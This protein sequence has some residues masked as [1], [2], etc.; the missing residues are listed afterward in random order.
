M[1]EEIDAFT[2]Y[3]V[4]IRKS[5]KNTVL[6]YRRDLLQLLSYLEKQGITELPKVTRTSLN[7]YILYLEGQ[8]KATATI[9]RVVASMKAFFHYE[10]YERKIYRDPSELLKTPRIEKKAPVILTVEEVEQLLRQPEGDTPKELRDKAMLEL[11]YATGIRVSELIRLKLEDV[12]LQVGFITCRDGQKERVIPFG[13]TA[14]RALRNY[15]DQAREQ[16]LKGKESPWLFVNCNGS[17]LSRQG[18]WKILKYYGEKAGI[19]PD[20]TPHMLRRSFAV[21]LIRR[22]ADLQS[23]KNMLG[24]ADL[25]T[26]QMYMNFMEKDTSRLEGSGARSG[27]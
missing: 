10:M 4:N 14:G 22:G 6:S 12:N 21:H 3:L 8:G 25:A 18:F 24:Y 17:S 20:I 13:K 19:L 15:L 2:E 9:S 16:M 11:L 27:E 5:S 26:T 7:S 23:V 1:L